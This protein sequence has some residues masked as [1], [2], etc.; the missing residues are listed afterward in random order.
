MDHAQ[1][2]INCLK[3]TTQ[4]CSHCKL[5]YYCS[6]RCQKQDWINHKFLCR[7]SLPEYCINLIKLHQFSSYKCYPSC[8]NIV[9]LSA[10]E[11]KLIINN[12]KEKI[13][14][15][16]L[17]DEFC[18]I[19]GY[20]ITYKGPLINSNDITDIIYYESMN[21]EIKVEYFKCEVCRIL[22]NYLCGK[23][24]EEAKQCHMNFKT[25]IIQF[26][27]FKNEYFDWIP[28]DLIYLL[29]QWCKKIKS[30]IV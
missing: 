3:K 12:K 11:H 13:K 10:P 16:G 6:Y 29:I 28:K 5:T 26:I 22:K 19:C 21:E 9:N 27:C 23:T 25:N 20:N 8:I 7:K 15:R 4:I 2:C 18:A 24:C 30:C 1:H 17:S 14:M